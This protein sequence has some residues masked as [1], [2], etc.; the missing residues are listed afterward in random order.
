MRKMS[1]KEVLAF[2][3]YFMSFYG[4]EGLYPDVIP[5]PRYAEVVAGITLRGKQFCG[6]SFD[7]EAIRDLILAGRGPAGGL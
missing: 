3:E 6:D 2:H 4:T 7:R 5:S 1:E